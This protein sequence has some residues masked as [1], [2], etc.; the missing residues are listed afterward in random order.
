MSIRII[1][2]IRNDSLMER[3]NV[4]KSRSLLNMVRAIMA[5]APMLPASVG[6]KKPAR[7]PPMT[8]IKINSGQ[9]TWGTERIRS[10]HENTGPLGPSSGLILH[11]PTTTKM[12][13]SAMMAPGTAPARKSLPMD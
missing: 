13:R 8:T 11:Q 4:L 5:I 6:V 2:D 12:N 7:R 9:A 1:A 10:L 3:P